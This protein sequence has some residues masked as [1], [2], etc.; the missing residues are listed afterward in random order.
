MAKSLE[1]MFAVGYPE[2]LRSIARSVFVELM[3]KY[4]NAVPNPRRELRI[5]KWSIDTANRI[6]CDLGGA[7]YYICKYHRVDLNA[8]N[9]EMYAEFKGNNYRSLSRKY[10]LTA[11]Q[12]RNIVNACR[13]IKFLERQMSLLT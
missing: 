12:V 13:E 3:S 2:T 6:S 5:A 4:S 9:W 7:S 1:D 10:N 11:T 8:R